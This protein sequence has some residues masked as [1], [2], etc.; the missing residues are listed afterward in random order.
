MI[1]SQVRRWII[2]LN[3]HTKLQLNSWASFTSKLCEEQSWHQSCQ[4][5][6]KKI[7]FKFANIIKLSIPH[8]IL[9]CYKTVNREQMSLI[10][11]V[12]QLSDTA[13]MASEGIYSN[14]HGFW[15]SILITFGDHSERFLTNGQ[16]SCMFLYFK[17]MLYGHY[18]VTPDNRGAE[19]HITFDWFSRK[20]VVC[21]EHLYETML[22]HRCLSWIQHGNDRPANVSGEEK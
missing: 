12:S 4:L 16:N 7:P 6:R 9:G 13:P 1:G 22:M 15:I 19:W 5:T 3:Y 17:P 11:W 14:W 2:I 18:L 20:P 21:N 10:A 8:A